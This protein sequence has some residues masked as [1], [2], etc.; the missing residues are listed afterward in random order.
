MKNVVATTQ[1]MLA[2][3]TQHIQDPEDCDVSTQEAIN[4]FM[5]YNF[6]RQKLWWEQIILDETS[7]AFLESLMASIHPILGIS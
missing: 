3:L 1:E 5:S 4:D 7:R 6:L 2:Y